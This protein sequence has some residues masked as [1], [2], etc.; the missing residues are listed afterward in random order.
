M[1]K[2][3]EGG[4]SGNIPSSTWSLSTVGASQQD[5]ISVDNPFFGIHSKCTVSCNSTWSGTVKSGDYLRG[6]DGNSL[7]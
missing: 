2:F 1:I 6:F 3:C 5:R 7:F 4:Y